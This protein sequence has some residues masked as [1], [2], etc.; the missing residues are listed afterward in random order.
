MES[1][2]SSIL[3]LVRKLLPFELRVMIYDQMFHVEIKDLEILLERRR[4]VKFH[5]IPPSKDLVRVAHP[6]LSWVLPSQSA[7]E[8][9]LQ[10]SVSSVASSA[11]AYSIDVM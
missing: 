10:G 9:F 1:S 6:P 11:M 4:Y 2:S 3:S 8:V 5:S 7:R